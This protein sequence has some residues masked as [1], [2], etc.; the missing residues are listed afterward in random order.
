MSGN[1]PQR[2]SQNTLWYCQVKACRV[3]ESM[4]FWPW[5]ARVQYLCWERAA[6]AELEFIQVQLVQYQASGLDDKSNNSL[7]Y[8]SQQAALKESFSEGCLKH[9]TNHHSCESQALHS[10][11]IIHDMCWVPREGSM[12]E[13]ILGARYAL[14]ADTCRPISSR[15]AAIREDH[16]PERLV[17]ISVIVVRLNCI[18]VIK[19]RDGY[20]FSY[21]PFICLQFVV[22]AFSGIIHVLWPLA[23]H[24]ADISSVMCCLCYLRQYTVQYTYKYILY[25]KEF[26]NPFILWSNQSRDEVKEQIRLWSATTASWPQPN[27]VA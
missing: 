20:P 8:S 12:K 1:S 2:G 24:L 19:P 27:L 3:W 25:S 21:C 15:R 9:A 4:H 23:G 13:T 14:L 16:W 5:M 10:V 7:N 11:N 6:S 26:Q 22:S 18:W 17:C